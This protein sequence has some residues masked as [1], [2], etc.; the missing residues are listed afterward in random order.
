MKQ[1]NNSTIR[2]YPAEP[3]AMI[4]GTIRVGI[5]FTQC[6]QNRNKGTATAGI[7]PI[8]L[9]YFGAPSKDLYHQ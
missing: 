2:T 8:W 6:K 7:Y 3:T 4:N 9:G 5:I 1:K